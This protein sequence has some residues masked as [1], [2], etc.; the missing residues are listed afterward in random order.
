[1]KRMCNFDIRMYDCDVR[2]VNIFR[3]AAEVERPLGRCGSRVCSQHP[4]RRG[5]IQ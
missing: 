4:M 5:L 1:M 2:M 3:G